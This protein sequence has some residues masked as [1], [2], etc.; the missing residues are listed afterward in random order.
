MLFAKKIIDRLH[1]IECGQRH[2]DEDRIPV[3]HR[4][5]PKSGKL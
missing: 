1:G 5:V 2:F 3:A 4:A